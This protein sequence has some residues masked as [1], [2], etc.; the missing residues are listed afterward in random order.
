MADTFKEI[1][2]I[3]KESEDIISAAELKKAQIISNSRKDAEKLFTE[4]SEALKKSGEAEINNSKNESEKARQKVL[5]ANK[6]KI[7][8]LRQTA[9]A[10]S[11]Q[12]AVDVLS[13]FERLFE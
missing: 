10:N 7:D 8:A 4:E 1:R 5:N 12:A 11:E 3:E 6:K 9:E 13:R 2:E